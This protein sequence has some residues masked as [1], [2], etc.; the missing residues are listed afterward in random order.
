MRK[1]F[2]PSR[3][4]L[5]F[6]VAFIA[7]WVALQYVIDLRLTTLAKLDGQ[8]VLDWSWPSEKVR[9]R[10]E[11]LGTEVLKRTDNDAVVR[12]KARQILERSIDHDSSFVADGKSSD[13]QAIL[14]YYKA[15]RNWFLGKVEMQ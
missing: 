8:R 9:A 4:L 15:H 6:C 2:T 1:L 14:T 3:M 5:L 7:I 13:C 10:A 11:V 12:V